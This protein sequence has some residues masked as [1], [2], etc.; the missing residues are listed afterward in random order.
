MK[1]NVVKLNASQLSQLVGKIV[2]EESNTRSGTIKISEGTL[3]KIIR[4]ELESQG[5]PMKRPSNSIEFKSGQGKGASIPIDDS[6][7]D[8]ILGQLG[9][10][11]LTDDEIGTLVGRLQAEAKR[12]RG[13]KLAEQ[14][15]SQKKS[16]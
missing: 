15:R 1:R 7:I 3:R 6:K 9:N 8:Q 10:L 5:D 14:R 4:E 11:S 13:R 2:K 12:R 16:K